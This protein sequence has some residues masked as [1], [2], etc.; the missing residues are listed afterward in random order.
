MA[1]EKKK[2]ILTAKR[3]AELAALANDILDM[4]QITGPPVKPTEIADANQ[5]SWNENVYHED[6]L[7]LIE[8]REDHFHIYVNLGQGEN[9][10]TPRVRFSIA[11]EL[12]HFFIPAHRAKLI[13]QGKLAKKDSPVFLQDLREKEA[14]FFASCLLMPEKWVKPDFDA[15]DLDIKALKKLS[16][17]YNTSTAALLSRYVALGK[18]P[19]TLVWSQNGKK[20]SI[21]PSK[22]F[23]F[24]NLNTGK[25]DTMPEHSLA[26]Q[27]YFSN[28]NEKKVRGMA[29]ASDIF[30]TSKPN[31]D[32]I[33]VSELCISQGNNGTYLS[34]FWITNNIG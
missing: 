14:E 29:C 8:Y 12:G 6:F 17:K 7:A 18:T 30:S 26:Y 5:I 9:I 32:E 22:N 15:L 21:Y 28:S 13:E 1:Q 16:K 10:H 20:N 31:A 4:M 19:I 3:K 33:F 34:V 11:H 24:Y 25:N 2:Q 27:N 23:P